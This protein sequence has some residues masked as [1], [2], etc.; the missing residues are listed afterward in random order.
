MSVYICKI[1]AN[2]Q[3]VVKFEHDFLESDIIVT[4]EGL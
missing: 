3:K 1:L 4:E 2:F